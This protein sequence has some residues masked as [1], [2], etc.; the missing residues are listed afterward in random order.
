MATGKL[1]R[2]LLNLITFQNNNSSIVRKAGRNATNDI[3]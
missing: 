2:E 1:F 3:V